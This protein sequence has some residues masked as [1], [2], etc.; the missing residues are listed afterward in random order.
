MD[1]VGG[2]IQDPG[3]PAGIA[4]CG[5]ITP[6]VRAPMIKNKKQRVIGHKE[7]S[8]FIRPVVFRPIMALTPSSKFWKWI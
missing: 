1:L 2:R 5:F 4:Y 8:F 7:S 6:F 3:R